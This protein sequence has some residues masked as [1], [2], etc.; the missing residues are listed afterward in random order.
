MSCSAQDGVALFKADPEEALKATDGFY[1]L[2]EKAK[3]ARVEK[4]VL[5]KIITAL[6]DKTKYLLRR[7]KSDTKD[8]KY[9]SNL[10]LVRYNPCLCITS[11][12]C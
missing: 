10:Q 12:F 9:L 11:E 5:S 4:T 7:S 1:P 3:S 8:I 6:N 2:Y